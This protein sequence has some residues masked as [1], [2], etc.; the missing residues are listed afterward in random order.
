MKKISIS[1]Y[2][3]IGFRHVTLE[4][5]TYQR[6]D[7]KMLIDGLPIAIKKLSYTNK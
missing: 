2:E 4:P 1:L 5:G 7:V 6:A 3:K